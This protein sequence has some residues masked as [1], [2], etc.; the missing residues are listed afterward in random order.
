MTIEKPSEY[1]M[2]VRLRVVVQA[3]MLRTGDSEGAV[4]ERL[5]YILENA[6]TA[7]D[8]HMAAITASAAVQEVEK[9]KGR[10]SDGN[11]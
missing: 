10:Q 3:I 5:L 7:A 11:Q 9:R 1:E 2:L 8:K 6:V 4:R